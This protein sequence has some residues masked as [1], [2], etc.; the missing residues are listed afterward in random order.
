MNRAEP[1]DINKI[2]YSAV[3]R[4]PALSFDPLLAY[5]SAILEWNERAGLVS[6]RD[7]GTVL[8]RLIDQSV[9][10]WQMAQDALSNDTTIG[11]MGSAV[12]I[13]S[14]AG[15]PGVIWKLLS[16]DLQV[17]LIDRRV[18]KA[19]FLERTVASLGLSGVDVFAGEAVAAARLARLAGT[20]DAVAAMAVGAIAE[21]A[22]LAFPFLQPGGVFV[23]VI[24]AGER[25]GEAPD[26]FA[27][28]TR[29]SDATGNR[30]AL[31]R[32]PDETV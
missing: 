32:A 1:H 19:T 14:G 26:G 25:S 13:G 5:L 9:R 28:A 24:P 22:P 11:C 30:I 4:H 27:V 17:T 8:T 16:P 29:E 20:R 7:P 2:T 10:L 15:F 23:T 3:S 6:P 31:R 18:R 12:D 21:T